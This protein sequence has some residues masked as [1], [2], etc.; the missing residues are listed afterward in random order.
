MDRPRY[1]PLIHFLSWPRPPEPAPPDPFEPDRR[2]LPA[3]FSVRRAEHLA[4]KRRA[5][6]AQIQRVRS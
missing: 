2:D 6:G 3:L 4:L 1:Q 5:R